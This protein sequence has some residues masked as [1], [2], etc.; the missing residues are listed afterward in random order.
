M[1]ASKDQRTKRKSS[2]YQNSCNNIIEDLF[3]RMKQQY[4]AWSVCEFDSTKN[5]YWKM[6]YE[7]Q[8]KIGEEAIA[9]WLCKNK[10]C[11]T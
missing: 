5:E 4:A 2:D 10:T 7:I 1:I 6:V 11:V 8:G 3:L 9:A